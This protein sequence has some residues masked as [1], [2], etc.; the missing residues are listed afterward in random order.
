MFFFSLCWHAV[1]WYYSQVVLTDTLISDVFLMFCWQTRYYV[2]FF[3]CCVDRQADKW[4]FSQVEG[5]D[6][7]MSIAARFETT[8]SELTKL[9]RLSTRYL[10]PGQSLLVP[11]RAG[12]G[13]TNPGSVDQGTRHSRHQPRHTRPRYAA[14]HAPTQAHS[15]K[16]GG[17]ARTNPGTLDQ[18]TRHSTH[19]PRRNNSV[20]V[21]F[22]CIV[23]ALLVHCVHTV[24]AVLVLVGSLLFNA[25]LVHYVH[26]VHAVLVLVWSLLFKE[27]FPVGVH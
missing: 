20:P 15:T 6:T 13:R 19:Q 10:F 16:V 24:R 8:P 18:G 22:Q 14:Q 21:S 23:D 7:L 11:L 25:L 5:S 12:H 1:K 27:Q 4:C 2:M 17:T 9:N 26:T 3:S